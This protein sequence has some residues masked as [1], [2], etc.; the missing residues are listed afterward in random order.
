[1]QSENRSRSIGELAYQ[2]WQAR[3]CPQ[4]T[5]E[6][7]W[8]DAERQLRAKQAVETAAT[9]KTAATSNAT[10]TPKATA[11]SNA[12]AAPKAIDDSLKVTFPATD[13]PAKPNAKKKAAGA[14]RKDPTKRSTPKQSK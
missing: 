10:A 4:G 14:S 2:L 8:L 11:T 7:D 9:P 12:T 13:P 3:G 6:Q 5:A 1:M